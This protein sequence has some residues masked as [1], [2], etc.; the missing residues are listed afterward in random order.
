MLQIL[1]RIARIIHVDGNE[2]IYTAKRRITHFNYRSS[3]PYGD[4]VLR[5]GVTRPLMW[6]GKGGL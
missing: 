1:H 3:L 4:D 5:V 2:T 6:S